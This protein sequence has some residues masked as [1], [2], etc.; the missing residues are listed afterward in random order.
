MNSKAWKTFVLAPIVLTLLAG[1]SGDKKN[2]GTESDSQFGGVWGTETRISTYRSHFTHHGNDFDGFCYAVLSD[3]SAYG[4]HDGGS[5]TLGSF[6]VHGDG[7]VMTYSVNNNS[8]D[9]FGAQE[10]GDLSLYT[11]DWGHIGEDGTFSRTQASDKRLAGVTFLKVNADT[12]VLKRGSFS[13]THGDLTY[14]RSSEKELKDYAGAVMGCLDAQGTDSRFKPQ[15][16]VVPLP[17]DNQG[18][19]GN[20]DQPGI[21]VN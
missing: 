16:K 9:A 14:F 21:T 11:Q 3:P 7:H 19:D 4:I 13:R 18:S 8:Q 17:K 5:V 15:G 1:C 10:R 2:A 20:P 12:L 6:I